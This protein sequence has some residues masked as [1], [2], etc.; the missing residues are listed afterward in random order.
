MKEITQYETTQRYFLDEDG[1]LYGRDGKKIKSTTIYL[2]NRKYKTYTRDKWYAIVYLNAPTDKKFYT[3][4]DY[5][6]Q[7]LWVEKQIWKPNSYVPEIDD[8]RTTFIYYLCDKKNGI[9]RYV[10]KTDNPKKRFSTHKRESINNR[11]GRLS[12]KEHWIDSVINDGSEIEMVII[13]EVVGDGT[14]GSGDW[15]W[16]EEYWGHQMTQW[17]FPIIFDGGWGY[18]GNRRKRTIE[19]KEQHRI[20][21][22][23]V[24][25]KKSYLYDIYNKQVKTFN[26]NK[27]C[28][29]FLKE[30]GNWGCDIK[31]IS[32][33]SIIDGKFLFSYSEYNWDEVYRIVSSNRNWG[34]KVL[35]FDISFKNIIN[36]F[37]T[38]HDAVEKTGVNNIFACLNPN[39]GNRKSAAGYRWVY[40][41]DYIYLGLDV[42]KE[43]LNY[44]NRSVVYTERMINDCISLSYSDAVEKYYGVLAHGTISNIRNNPK[45]Y[46]NKIGQTTTTNVRKTI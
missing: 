40:K 41:I 27:E 37:N 15:T 35:Q 44:K 5:R 23:F 10:G 22:Q 32:N 21:Q 4:R 36:E 18:G 14:A 13:D 43:K 38:A 39:R 31:S 17:G 2:S 34:M 6:G 25:G 9:P 46:L 24:L 28:C 3:Y 11:R 33:D 7:L 42:I 1:Y 20:I 16:V 8:F 45:K 26:G 29:R 19:E 30:N 12:H